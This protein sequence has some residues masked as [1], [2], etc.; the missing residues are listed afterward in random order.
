MGLGTGK[1]FFNEKW[2]KGSIVK[3]LRASIIKM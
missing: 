2:L 3:A 1:M